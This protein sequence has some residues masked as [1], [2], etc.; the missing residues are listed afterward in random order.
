V[1]QRP[2]RNSA[3]S[4]AHCCGDSRSADTGPFDL[5]ASGPPSAP[6]RRHRRTGPGVTRRSRAI[7]LTLSPAANRPAA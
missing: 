2:R 6:A 7:A 4:R 5:S 1:R 3:S